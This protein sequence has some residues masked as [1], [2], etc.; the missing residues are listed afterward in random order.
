MSQDAELHA[1]HQIGADLFESGRHHASA[2]V[3]L[4]FLLAGIDDAI[5]AGIVCE[6]ARELLLS[7]RA[8]VVAASA[9]AESALEATRTLFAANSGSV[10]H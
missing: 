5:K 2:T 4:D 1:I 10:W 3:S 9:H 7:A 8:S 6:G